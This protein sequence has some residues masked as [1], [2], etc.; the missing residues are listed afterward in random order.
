MADNI[1][2][3]EA[4]KRQVRRAY[5]IKGSMTVTGWV[6]K[7]GSADLLPN[8]IRIET[9]KVTTLYQDVTL[10]LGEFPA[11][12]PRRKGGE[13]AVSSGSRQNKLQARVCELN[14]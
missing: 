4:F 3:S 9:K 2:Y 5:G 12:A 1:Q 13:V 7:Y 10:K 11:K 8:L 6:R 14:V